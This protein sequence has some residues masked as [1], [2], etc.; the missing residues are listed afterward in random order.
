MSPRYGRDTAQRILCFDSCQL[1]ITDD[2]MDVKVV[3]SVYVRT[4]VRIDK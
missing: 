4:Y 1:M 3:S 2:N